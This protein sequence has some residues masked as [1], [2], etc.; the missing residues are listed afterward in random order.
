[1][2]NIN[3]HNTH[4]VS[5]FEYYAPETL[6]EASKL[7]KELGKDAAALAGGTEVIVKMKDGSRRPKHIVNLKKIPGL[8][9]IKETP[10]GIEIGALTTIREI[11]TCSLVKEKYPILYEAARVLGSIQIRNRA[12]VGG[13][14]CNAS[15]CADSAVGLLSV[16][17]VAHISGLEGEREVPLVEFFLGPG[18]TVLAPGEILTSITVPKM[19]PGSKSVF[20]RVARASMDMATISLAAVIT[21]KNGVVE[22]SRLAW[23]TVAPT[24]MRTK[25]VEEFLKGKKL[26][27]EVIDEA[28]EL[29]SKSIKPREKGRSNGPYKRRV[30]KGFIVETLSKLRES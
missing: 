28:A 27:D 30:A 29:A 18:R 13:N 5:D 12:T 16:D 9:G 19:A 11:E 3:I 8:S 10:D 6:E 20:N 1:M 26:T 21:M 7:L 24:P 2:P 4:I 25:D 17:A 15:P 23:G 22:D 14:I